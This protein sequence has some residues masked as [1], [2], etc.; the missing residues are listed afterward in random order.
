MFLLRI[1]LRPPM[2]EPHAPRK[3]MHLFFYGT[4]THEHANLA[5]REVLLRLVLVGRGRVAGQL[6]AV[7]TAQGW[8][9]ALLP[10]DGQVSGWVYRAGAGFD[11]Q[12]LARLDAWED[13]DPRRPRRSEYLRRRIPVQLARGRTLIA[14][15]YLWN[16]P[17][18]PAMVPLPGGDFTAWLAAPAR[19]PRLAFTGKSD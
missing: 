11:A 9:P 4:L 7:P 15:A 1:C 13:Y 17:V 12:C 19:R 8:Y 14:Q 6:H 3:A 18:V 16:R 2:A 10:G 5:T